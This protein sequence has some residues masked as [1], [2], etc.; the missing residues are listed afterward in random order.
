MLLNRPK[1]PFLAIS[2]QSTQRTQSKKSTKVLLA[3]ISTAEFA[4]SAEAKKIYCADK[5]E[6]LYDNLHN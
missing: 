3:Q 6:P 1:T 5:D 2:P 4:E